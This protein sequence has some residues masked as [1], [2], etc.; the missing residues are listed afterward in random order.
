MRLAPFKVHHPASVSE[1]LEMRAALG[2]DATFYAGG[3]EILLV[4]KLGLADYGHLIDLK[5]IEELSKWGLHGNALHIGA[6]VAYTRLECDPAVRT[7][8]S[9]FASM[10]SGI[11]NL[12]V[13]S[14]GTLG[15]NLAFADPHSDP[16]TFL[17][18]LAGA[19]TISDKAG[20]ER[21]CDVADLT[22]GPYTTQVG[23]DEM[24]TSINVP[25]PD[26]SIRVVH[27][28]VRFRERPALTVTASAEVIAN[29]A[30]GVAVAL[31]SVCGAP[32]RLGDVERLVEGGG[33]GASGDIREAASSAVEPVDDLDGSA[34][35]K[36]HLTG[37]VVARAVEALFGRSESSIGEEAWR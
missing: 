1:A 10:L 2:E 18:A 16:A 15:G 3:T 24:I 7:Q 22:L 14:V 35:Y 27:R 4:M 28:H 32:L 9:S 21:V 26:P 25:I 5:G 20:G 13:R 36:R 8:F 12:R 30:S 37:V 34:D 31:G 23:D 33:L 19:V 6:S 11:G 17:T 29:E